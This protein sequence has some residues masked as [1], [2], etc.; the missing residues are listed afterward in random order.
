MSQAYTYTYK[1]MLCNIDIN[2]TIKSYFFLS[3]WCSHSRVTNL[4]VLYQMYL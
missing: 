1:Y 3:T 4:P 2:I